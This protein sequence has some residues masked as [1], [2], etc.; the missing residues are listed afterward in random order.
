MLVSGSTWAGET[1]TLYQRLGGEG[2]VAGV[3]NDLVDRA[4]SDVRT[5][6]SFDGVDLARLKKLL[7]EQICAVTHGPCT[8]T[9]DSMKDVHEGL[10]IPEAEFFRM[11]EQLR[12]IMIE[13]G[14]G[15]RERNELLAILAPMKRDVVTH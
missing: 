4:A 7:A 14:V 1:A 2:V 12:E 10:K 13:H 8:Y 5:K 6:R 15:L 3:V 9:G 11:V